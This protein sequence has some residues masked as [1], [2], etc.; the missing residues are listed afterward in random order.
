ML[1]FLPLHS[2]FL[3][4]LHVKS[5]Y[6]S[7]FEHNQYFTYHFHVGDLRLSSNRMFICFGN[8]FAILSR[9]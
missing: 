9:N 4:E 3:R 2:H 7:K 8:V 6:V 1:M 5:F